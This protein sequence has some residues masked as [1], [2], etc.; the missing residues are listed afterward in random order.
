MIHEQR[1]V[2]DEQHA[3]ELQ[4]F[5]SEYESV[6]QKQRVSKIIYDTFVQEMKRFKDKLRKIDIDL[7]EKAL[8]EERLASEEL[9]RV[10][11]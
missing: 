6:A 7:K 2:K 9:A 5:N 10:Q 3:F 1:F 8:E 11:K 4:A